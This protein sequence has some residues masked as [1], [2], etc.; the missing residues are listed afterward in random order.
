V[1]W[2]R[3]IIQESRERIAASDAAVK[4]TQSELAGMRESLDRDRRWAIRFKEALDRWR[5]LGA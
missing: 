4:Q 2:V 3:R 1:A 5:T